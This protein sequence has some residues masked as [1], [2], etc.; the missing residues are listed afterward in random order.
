M[1]EVNAVGVHE[2]GEARGAANA[3]Y[4][5]DL[6]MRNAEF[7]DDIEKGSE[8]SEVATSGAP[9]RVIGFELLLGELFCGSSG[10]DVGH[11][12]KGLF[13]SDEL[14][15]SSNDIED[16]EADSLDFID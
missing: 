10:G 13:V 5:A 15:G 1:D 8:N 7:L 6:L 9:S 14:L 4:D 3:G 12:M 11:G 16:A 2:I